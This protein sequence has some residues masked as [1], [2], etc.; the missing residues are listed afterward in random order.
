MKIDNTGNINALT[1][2]LIQN[3]G[4]KELV[5]LGQTETANSSLNTKQFS[6]LSQLLQLLNVFPSLYRIASKQDA[7]SPLHV[8]LNNLIAPKDPALLAKW[9]AERQPDKALIEALTL[10]RQRT[11]SDESSSLKA[12]IQLLAEQRFQTDATKPGEFTWLFCFGTTEQTKVEVSVK[13][14]TPKIRKKSRWSVSVNLTLSNN[15]QLT[16]T[17]ELED[18]QLD[19]SFSTDSDALKQLVEKSQ[20][21]LEAQLSKH[22]ISVTSCEVIT[23]PTQPEA[24]IHTGLNIQV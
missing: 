4:L 12:A 2:A 13:K 19:L 10:L 6:Q 5:K 21:V 7:S 15:R 9:L 16:A 3:N 8:L 1:L 23:T 11:E 20:P 24:T 14:K 22:S 17:A 18:Q